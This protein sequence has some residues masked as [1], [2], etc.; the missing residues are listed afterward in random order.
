MEEL[1]WMER[2]AD[3]VLFVSLTT[4]EKAAE[5]LGTTLM[6]MGTTV[7][8]LILLWGIIAFISGII[9][10]AEQKA[11]AHALAKSVGLDV[12][13]A[14]AVARSLNGRLSAAAQ[15]SSARNASP[16]RRRCRRRPA[17]KSADQRSARRRSAMA[18]AVSP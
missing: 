3:P 9:R 13:S 6:G 17:P 18:A 1:G 7:M 5:S 2:F 8:I 11:A 15:A 14:G 4:G 16:W 12:K 10:R